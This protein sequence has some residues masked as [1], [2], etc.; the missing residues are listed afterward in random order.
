MFDAWMKRPIIKVED[1]AARVSGLAR[2]APD[3]ASLAIASG[4]G[5]ASFTLLFL[6]IL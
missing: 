6:F 5:G 3:V 1:H 4:D 2:G